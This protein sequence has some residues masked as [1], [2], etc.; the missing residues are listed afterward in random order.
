MLLLTEQKAIRRV[1]FSDTD[2]NAK[3]FA[4]IDYRTA[5]IGEVGLRC[6]GDGEWTYTEFKRNKEIKAVP[7]NI[8]TDKNEFSFLHVSD[9]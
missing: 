9:T 8:D 1:N 3:D 5:D 2:N 4:K 6:S 7:L